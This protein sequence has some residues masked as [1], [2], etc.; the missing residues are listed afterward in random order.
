M[1]HKLP[2]EL[3]THVALYLEDD[4]SS[5]P[6]YARVCRQWQPVFE[7]LIYR[8]LKVSTDGAELGKGAVSLSQFQ[9]LMSDPR[10]YRP[11]FLRRLDYTIV[12][13][14]E[15]E[16]YSAMKLESKLYTERNP[17]RQANNEAFSQGIRSL[18]EILK[19]WD[20]HLKITLA[21][22]VH[23]R[24]KTLEPETEAIQYAYQ[25]QTV[26]DGQQWLPVP[27]HARFPDDCPDMP[28]VACVDELLFE[29]NYS[30]QGIWSGAAMQIAEH[31][32]ALRRI[33]LH[34]EELVRPDHLDYIRER[35]QGRLSLL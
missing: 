18:F 3:W 9:S 25:W 4:A 11:S 30:Y 15:I 5:F 23:G 27:Y 28:R 14:H 33:Y 26:L 29:S 21:M 24:E 7:R 16:D 32:V 20:A 19:S 31:C 22:A 13:P 10:Q 8:S 1:A 17:V 6:K 34:L 35:R 2:F 12:T